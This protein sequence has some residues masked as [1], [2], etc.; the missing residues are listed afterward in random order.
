LAYVRCKINEI[1]I[2]C[3]GEYKIIAHSFME[4]PNLYLDDSE[5]LSFN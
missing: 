4:F 5:S 1:Y 2:V 3:N